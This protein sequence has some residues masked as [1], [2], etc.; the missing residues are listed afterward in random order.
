MAALPERKIDSLKK[1]VSDY[2]NSDVYDQITT[3]RFEREINDL[4]RTSPSDKVDCFFLLGLFGDVKR[5]VL[6]I[7]KYFKLAL[8]LSDNINI[9]FHYAQALVYI[10]G[11]EEEAVSRALGCYNFMIDVP[12]MRH[13]YLAFYLRAHSLNFDFQGLRELCGSLKS[14][15]DLTMQEKNIVESVGDVSKLADFFD[16]MEISY[17]DIIPVVRTYKNIVYKNRLES[18]L[19]FAFNLLGDE[20]VFLRVG[21]EAD[22]NICAELNSELAEKLTDEDALAVYDKFTVVFEPY[23]G[24][25]EGNTT[26]VS[27]F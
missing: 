13:Q 4:I 19:T 26:N 23:S 15:S 12:E 7:D 8:N 17:R 16:R 10:P 25:S 27:R 14:R 2:I 18:E 21:V 1:R 11:R 5:D 24:G 3:A 9:Q 20:G 22:A 6:S